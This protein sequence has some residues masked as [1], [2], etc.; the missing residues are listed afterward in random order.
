MLRRQGLLC[1]RRLLQGW[2]VQQGWGLLL[3]KQEVRCKLRLLQGQQ[4]CMRQG[5]RM[6]LR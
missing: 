4:V 2:E 6:Q 5:R 3:Q 1:D